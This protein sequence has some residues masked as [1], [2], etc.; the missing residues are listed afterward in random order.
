MEQI[1]ASRI[2]APIKNGSTKPYYIVC[3]NGDTYAVKFKEN[4]QGIKA[5]IN[6]YICSELAQNLALP[7]PR[8]ALINISEDF[9]HLYGEKL[10]SFLGEQVSNGIHFGTKKIKKAYAIEDSGSLGAMLDYATNLEV[11]SELFI[12]DLFICNSDRDSNGGN[13]LFDV[14]DRKIIV[15]DHTHAFDLGTIWDAT[16]LNNRIGEPFRVLNPNGYVYRRLIP[17]VTGFNPFKNIL[18]KLERMTSEEIWHIIKS[19]PEEWELHEEEQLSLHSY[20][21]DRKDRIKDALPLLKPYMPYW[22]GGV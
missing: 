1:N 13:L 7:V 17:Y 2:A 6:E 16:Q 18:E 20:L 5:I 8:P 9:C 11:I 3:D 10:N 21:V 14:S 12:F 19:V 15:L 22:K 4:P